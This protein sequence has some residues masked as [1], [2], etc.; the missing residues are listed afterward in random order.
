MP[1]RNPAHTQC[2]WE[3][4]GTWS[5]GKFAWGEGCPRCLPQ[6]ALWSS[7][8]WIPHHKQPRRRSFPTPIR[9][10]LHAMASGKHINNNQGEVEGNMWKSINIKG[11]RTQ[12]GTP[13]FSNEFIMFCVSIQFSKEIVLWLRVYLANCI[14]IEKLGRSEA[15]SHEHLKVFNK[16]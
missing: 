5:D 16:A 14:T 15:T 11:I 7:Q 6:E 9:W 12:K 3:V 1:G 8:S 13:C 10:Q 4:T 2:L